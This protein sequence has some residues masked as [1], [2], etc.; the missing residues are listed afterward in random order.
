[1]ARGPKVCVFGLRASIWF[2]GVYTAP[3]R[4]S[5]ELHEASKDSG[6]RLSSVISQFEAGIWM[7]L[8]GKIDWDCV[9]LSGTHM[10]A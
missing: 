6:F 5:L 10:T 1:M 3:G 8:L 4:S 9:G 2:Q 7:P